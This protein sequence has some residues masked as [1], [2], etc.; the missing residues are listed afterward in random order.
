MKIT[1]RY[2]PPIK[3]IFL[4]LILISFFPVVLGVYISFVKF[5]LLAFILFTI[6]YA[7]I[8]IYVFY[9]LSQN[10]FIEIDEEENMLM[11]HKNFKTIEMSLDIISN[12]EIYEQKRAYILEITTKQEEGTRNYSLSGSLSFE[13][14]PVVP[15]LR[16]IKELKPIV[17]Y[18]EYA[19][20]ILKG[21]SNFNPWSKK[22][23]L[24]YWTYI[25]LLIAY[26]LLIL[27]FINILK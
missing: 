9:S 14:P 2:V 7:F 17:N 8:M 12:I 25:S 3:G 6:V 4:T 11:I 26:Y 15:F 5:G 22:M 13:E 24:S 20:S 16:K 27:V 19:T 18:G 23:Y 1:L 21:S 10:N